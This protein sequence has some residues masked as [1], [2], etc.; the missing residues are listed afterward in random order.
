V[1]KDKKSEKIWDP[2]G[3]ENQTSGK[4]KWEGLKER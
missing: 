2:F 3:D 4:I 1:A